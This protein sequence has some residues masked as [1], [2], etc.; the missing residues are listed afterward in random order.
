MFDKPLFDKPF[1]YANGSKFKMGIWIG[2]QMTYGAVLASVF[3]GFLLFLFLGSY[4]V[5]MMLP[6][7]S[8]TAPSPYTALETVSVTEVA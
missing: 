3:V 2:R 7:E 1:D 5:G 4:V 8:K 6:E